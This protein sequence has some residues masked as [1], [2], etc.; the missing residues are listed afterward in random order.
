M[1]DGFLEA[2]AIMSKLANETKVQDDGKPKYKFD[3][4]RIYFNKD[5]EVPTSN[6]KSIL[7]RVPTIGEIIK[8]EFRFYMNLNFIISNPTQF[9]LQLWEVGMDWNKMTDFQLFQLLY[10]AL[11]Y[12]I[13]QLFIPEVDFSTFE[14]MQKVIS[15]SEPVT[16]LY[17]ERYDIEI[18]EA[19]YD[20]LKMYLRT[21]FNIFPKV[22]KAKGKT[23]KQAIIDEEKLNLAQKNKKDEDSSILLPLVS[24]CINHAGF[25][26]NVKELED[27]GVFQFMD[28]VSRLQIYEST[29]ALLKGMYSGFVDTKNIKNEDMN[30]MRSI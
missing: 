12:D 18:D 5:Y 23:T 22:E 3:K 14:V 27:I 1:M 19:T 29:T 20:H 26:Y 13:S 21:M 4:L 28:S 16:V 10:K 24:S 2:S 25:K 15:E 6:G 17:S 11:E 9:R 30:F 8:D 7:V